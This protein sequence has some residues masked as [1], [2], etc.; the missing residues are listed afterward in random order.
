MDAT[1][2]CTACALE[3]RLEATKCPHCRTSQPGAEP[4]H[5]GVAGRTLGGVC[6]ALAR[7]FGID[8]AILRVGFV[9]SLAVSA[10][11]TLLVYLLLWG[12]TPASAT[13]KPPV[14]R[15]VDWVANVTDAAKDE[16]TVERRV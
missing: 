14:Q 11:T 10:G 13:G 15:V 5:R 7:Q 6:A 3:L 8:V 4:M 12:L 16:P 1:K 9:L 2:R